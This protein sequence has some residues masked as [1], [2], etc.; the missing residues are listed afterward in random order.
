MKVLSKYN[1]ERSH[2]KGNIMKFTAQENATGTT[3][4]EF[5]TIVASKDWKVGE[6]KYFVYSESREKFGKN[7]STIHIFNPAVMDSNEGFTFD[8]TKLIAQWGCHVLDKN[9]EA[10]KPGQAV[11]I[12]LKPTPGDKSY[13]N[14][15]VD[16][17]DIV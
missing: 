12:T 9:L 8:G 13:Y 17:G 4:Q 16:L 3:S 6:E 7:E 11:K 2:N 5:E 1:R 14:F 10:A 15:S